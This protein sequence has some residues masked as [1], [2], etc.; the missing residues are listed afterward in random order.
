MIGATIRPMSGSRKRTKKRGPGRPPLGED[1]L[2]E[3]VKVR[4]KAADLEAV[5]AYA[6]KNDLDVSE[7]YRLGAKLFIK[8]G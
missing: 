7:V 4:E 3:V 1:A 6:A 2:S 5:R 8:H